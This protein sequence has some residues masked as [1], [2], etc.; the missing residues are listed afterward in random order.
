MS[1]E[2]AVGL[3]TNKHKLRINFQHVLTG[4]TV[5]FSAFLTDFSDKWNSEWESTSVYGRMDD[6][7]TFRKTTRE[8]TIGWD[9]VAADK[10][11]AEENLIKC[12]T[13]IS[14]LYPTYSSEGGAG[15]ISGSPLFKLKFANLI[16]DPELPSWSASVSD[17]GLVG[18]INGFDYKPEL[19]PSFFIS[20]EQG[21]IAKTV[22]MSCTFTVLHTKPVGWNDGSFRQLSYPYGFGNHGKVTAT[23]G[24][25]T[26]I[27][28][29]SGAGGSKGAG[30]VGDSIGAGRGVVGTSASDTVGAGAN[31]KSAEVAAEVEAAAEAAKS[32]TSKM[33]DNVGANSILGRLL[34]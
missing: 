15:S 29:T 27:D 23:A 2:D 33:I 4:R 17:A 10:L 16:S 25:A 22:K 1:Y 21:L 31:I 8:I 6:I 14:M 30:S 3:L 11:E 28:G 26:G 9:V 7:K 18:T 19:E 24:G 34:R 13:L 20:P 12:S 5:F 32:D